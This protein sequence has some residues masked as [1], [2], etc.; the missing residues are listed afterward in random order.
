MKK[1][2][3]FMLLCCTLVFS[4]VGCGSKSK[5]DDKGSQNSQKETDYSEY[6]FA[7]VRW[8]RD[9]DCDVETIYFNPN[10]EFQYSCACGSSVNDS[11]VV[12][13]YSY[14]DT[15][16]MF[17]L[18]CCEEIEDMITEIKLVNCDGEVLELDF[19]GDV[20]KFSVKGVDN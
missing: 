17:T 15:T 10:G 4:L 14:D 3:I 1:K 9:T 5:K 19:D 12:D 8:T 20:R 16:K 6:N 18:N 11:D 13:S 2:I 7:G